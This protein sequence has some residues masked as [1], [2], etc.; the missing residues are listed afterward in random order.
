MARETV[1]IIDDSAELRSV[2][3]NILSFDSY[4]VLSA[5]TGQEGLDLVLQGHPDLILIDLELPDTNGLKVLEKL[6]EQGLTIPTIMMTGYGSEGVAARALRL[7]VRDY[8][9]KPFTAEEVLSSVERALAESRLRQEKD[10]LAAFVDGYARHIRLV[11]AVGRSVT[12][13]LALDEALQHIVATGLFITRAEAGFSLLLDEQSQTLRVMAA[14]GQAQPATEHFLPL[15]G[16]ERLRPVLQERV[17]VRIRASDASTIELQTGDRVRAVL[18]VA[19]QGQ[20]RSLGLLS[21]DR[22][23]TNTPFSKYDE[24]ILMILADYV[25]LGLSLA[26]V[27]GPSGEDLLIG[28]AQEIGNRR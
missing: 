5:S 6:N 12:A 20:N 10:Q 8:L 19:L 9:I 4:Q 1:L 17:A 26:G 18:Q 11:S 2:L 7:G 22:R 23:T 28:L 13:G 21:V 3:E 24:Q 27:S 16:D 15:S 25:T 14:V